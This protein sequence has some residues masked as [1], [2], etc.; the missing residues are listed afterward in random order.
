MN[1][2]LIRQINVLSCFQDPQ[3]ITALS[4][5]LTNINVLVSDVGNKYVVR[6]GEDI[7][8]HGVMRWN[9]LAVSNAAS[10]AGFSPNVIHNEPGVLV[11][12]F[13]D[14]K[15]FSED[16]VRDPDNLPHIVNL[17]KQ[18]HSELSNHVTQPVLAFWPFQ[19]NRNYIKRLISDNSSH[20]KTLPSLLKHNTKLESATGR[21]EMV[22]GHN[23]LLAANILDDGKKLWLIDWE[24]AGFN[25]PLFDLAGLASNNSLSEDQERA[26]LTQYFNE[27][28][29]VQW[30][31]YLAMK[32]SSLL[33][34]T[35]WSM[36]S[37]IHS[38]LDVDYAQYTSENMQRLES[39]FAD[40]VNT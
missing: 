34:E 6:L 35:L 31:S 25:S 23:D 2:Q 8:E 24:Y 4:G 38:D 16:D 28:A 19:V 39:A 33:R 40:F 37:E 1:E 21:V 9:E 10:S 13:I 30:R 27:G 11:L 15:T 20:Q 7:P 3:D 12:D 18:V 32:C 22:I 36:T 14:G 29:D 26:M 17:I 5:G